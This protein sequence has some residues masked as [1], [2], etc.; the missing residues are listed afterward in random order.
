[1]KRRTQGIGLKRIGLNDKKPGHTTPAHHVACRN[2]SELW[3]RAK[4]QCFKLFVTMASDITRA[5]SS[6]S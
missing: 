1:M 5:H 2:K 4:L 3:A 6:P